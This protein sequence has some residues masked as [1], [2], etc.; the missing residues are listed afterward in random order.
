MWLKLT[1]DFLQL[2][3]D[4]TFPNLSAI[5][6]YSPT[7]IHLQIKMSIQPGPVNSFFHLAHCNQILKVFQVEKQFSKQKDGEIFSQTRFVSFFQKKQL[8]PNHRIHVTHRIGSGL[9]HVIEFKFI[10]LQSY[11]FWVC[12]INSRELNLAIMISR[13]I[14]PLF[15]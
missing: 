5:A 7:S 8:S 15:P 6:S 1:N 10:H 4:K 3:F 11:R 14:I 12:G 2:I 13:L 9:Q